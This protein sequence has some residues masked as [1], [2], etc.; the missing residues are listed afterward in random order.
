MPGRLGSP[1]GP[2]MWLCRSRLDAVRMKA[3]KSAGSRGR[4]TPPSPPGSMVPSPKIAAME[5]RK[6]MRFRSLIASHAVPEAKRTQGA[7]SGAPCP[8]FFEGRDDSFPRA[9]LRGNECAC[10]NGSGCSKIES[11][12]CAGAGY[13]PPPPWGGS[14]ERSG[15]RGGGAAYALSP[16]TRLVVRCAH[17]MP[18]SPQGGGKEDHLRGTTGERFQVKTY[19]ALN[20]SRNRSA[21]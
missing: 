13:F 1:S 7:P 15:G 14:A 6:A 17:N 19:K 20:P 21:A 3:E 4:A 5:R 9:M 12:S 10:A 18:P 2:T 8:S 11:E 16:P